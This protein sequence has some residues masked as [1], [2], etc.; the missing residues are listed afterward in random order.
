MAINYSVLYGGALV[1]L[2][3]LPEGLQVVWTIHPTRQSSAKFHPSL[4]SKIQPDLLT[5]FFR[6]SQA[7]RINPRFQLVEVRISVLFQDSFQ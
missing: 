7:A 4:G 3:A 5:L 2:L 1:M 6:Q